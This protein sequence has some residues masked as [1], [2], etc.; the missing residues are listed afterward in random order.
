[1]KQLK[2]KVNLSK[3]AENEFLYTGLEINAN[4][5]MASERFSN[6]TLSLAHCEN[7]LVF[8]RQQ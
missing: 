1:M 4:S 2:E 7:N 8:H 5:S 6:F 3:E